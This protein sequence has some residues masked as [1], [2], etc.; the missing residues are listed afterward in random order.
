MSMY[1]ELVMGGANLRASEKT[2]DV[3]GKKS[4]EIFVKIVVLSLH[5]L[6]LLP[7]VNWAIALLL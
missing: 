1:R 5:S 2:V 3:R 4:W 7:Q 6:A